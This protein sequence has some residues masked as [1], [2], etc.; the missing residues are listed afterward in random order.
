MKTKN[1][2]PTLLAVTIQ[3]MVNGQTQ[4]NQS[5][6]SLPVLED[7]KKNTAKVYPTLV[8]EE[9]ATIK[10]LSFTSK[11]ETTNDKTTTIDNN[12]FNYYSNANCYA[13]VTYANEL[14]KQ[15]DDLGLIEKTL[16]AQ[17]STKKGEEKIK[18]VN[19]AN[20]LFKQAELKQI[21]ASEIAGKIN[22][23]KYKSNSIVFN[24][25]AFTSVA[26]EIILEKAKEINSEASHNI[27]LA[28]EMREEAYAMHNNTAKLG[29]MSNAE[30]K[31]T[32]ALSKQDEAIGILKQYAAI[33]ETM[34][35]DLAVR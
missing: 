32:I 8:S 20:E 28:K 23:E 11:T 34:M 14:L 35:N 7:G 13:T 31:E 16:R 17:A 29:T 33:F 6:R 15:A 21:Q 3:V 30:E 25:M 26:G 22:H 9:R 10:E 27:K 5:H 24:N 19:A 2:L 4:G 1:F 18:L 12:T